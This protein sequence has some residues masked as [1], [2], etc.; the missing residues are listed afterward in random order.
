MPFA[1][2]T[3]VNHHR[4][5]I[6]FSCALV[7]D[8]REETFVWLFRQ[9]LNCMWNESPRAIITD[10]DLA[11]DNAIKKVFPHTH[12]RYCQ[13]HLGLH[14]YCEHLRSLQ[15]DHP[16]FNEDYNMWAK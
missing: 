2:F 3:G 6:L 8:E 4:Q 16:T 11:I 15:C 1:P 5:S 9:W 12:H 7:S 13:W 10:Q 14:E